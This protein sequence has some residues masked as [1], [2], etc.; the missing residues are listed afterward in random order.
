[1]DY[2]FLPCIERLK[3]SE[4]LFI[5]SGLQPIAHFDRFKGQY[6]NPDLHQPWAKPAIF[7]KFNIAWENQSNNTQKG[8]GTM[9]VHL[10]LENYSESYAGSPDQALALLDYEYIRVV[11]AI[12]H[13]FRTDKFQSLARV[14]TDEDENPSNTNVTII[15]FSFEILDES[16]DRYR[17]W[18]REKLD[19]VVTQKRSTE[20][21]DDDEEEMTYVI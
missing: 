15:R 14:T 5:D 18:L 7:F 6:L 10:E 1:M 16:M 9:E 11:S 21:Q 17:N 3:A 13:G 4:Q 19:D 2:I 20:D 8:T 12:L